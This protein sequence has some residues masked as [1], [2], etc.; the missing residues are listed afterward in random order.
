MNEKLF[1]DFLLELDRRDAMP[2]T[3]KKYLVALRKIKHLH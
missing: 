1:R 3:K 2:R